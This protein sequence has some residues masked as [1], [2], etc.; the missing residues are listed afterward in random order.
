MTDRLA[1]AWDV[2]EFTTGLVEHVRLTLT[3]TDWLKPGIS[4]ATPRTRLEPFLA[5]F[6]VEV[7]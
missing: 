5:S 3:Q 4:E 2:V 1:P 6:L 7:P